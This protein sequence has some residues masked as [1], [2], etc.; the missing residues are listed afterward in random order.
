MLRLFQLNVALVYVATGALKA[1]EAPWWDGTAVWRS[2]GS[3]HYW[4]FDLSGLLAH[5]WTFPLTKLA[6]WAT[7]AWELAFPLVF[8]KRLRPY[9][10][11]GGVAL[12]AGIVVCL[13]IGP[14]SEVMIWSYL[15]F[16]TFRRTS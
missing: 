6:T 3:E 10:L 16:F 7:L 13:N 14:F 4:R 8:W 11:L 5:P 12:H 2:L 15:A 9:M 1:L